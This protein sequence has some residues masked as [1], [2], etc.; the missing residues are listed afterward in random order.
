MSLP[1]KITLED[2]HR[3][4]D[5]MQGVCTSC[6]AIRESTEPDAEELTCDSCDEPAVVGVMTAFDDG[7]VVLIEEAS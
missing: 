2:Y 3:M 5:N 7:V 6:G 4:E 1:M